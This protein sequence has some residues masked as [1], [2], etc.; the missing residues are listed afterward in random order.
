MDG[1]Q[2]DL[3]DLQE[4][5]KQL[6]PHHRQALELVY[7]RGMTHREAH[8]HMEVPLGTFKSYVQQALKKLRTLNPLLW[9]GLVSMTAWIV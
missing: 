4:V 7:F 3:P 2:A 6:E 1:P 9:L 5:M 8:Q